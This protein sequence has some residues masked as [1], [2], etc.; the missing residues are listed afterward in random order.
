MSGGLEPTAGAQ[1]LS[2]RQLEDRLQLTM[3]VRAQIEKTGT[4]SREQMRVAVESIGLELPA[5]MPLNSYTQAPSRQNVEPTQH[6]LSA[7][8][9]KA[10]VALVGSFK[11]E[12]RTVLEKVTNSRMRNY[13]SLKSKLNR[14]QMDAYRYGGFDVTSVVD[15]EEAAIK[16]ECDHISHVM[17]QFEK[18]NQLGSESICPF[19]GLRREAE[20]LLVHVNEAIATKLQFRSEAEA[21]QFVAMIGKFTCK[22]SALAYADKEN[23]SMADGLIQSVVEAGQH[24]EGPVAPQV[25]YIDLDPDALSE[26]QVL[27]GN[28]VKVVQAIDEFM[29]YCWK[30]DD[31][32]AQ[33]VNTA[34]EAATSL[35]HL[36]VLTA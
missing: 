7:H 22:V 11:N 8:Q 16:A 14:L 12:L 29:F 28:L 26:Q 30:V 5:D 2:T 31:A 13:A 21:D 15:R 24:Y 3:A 35:Y 20:R 4:V 33:A 19:N 34:S 23:P 6:V 10:L 27:E 17:D 32:F 1:E 18:Y 25:D 9:E 36:K